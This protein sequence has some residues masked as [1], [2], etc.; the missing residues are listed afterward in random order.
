M[1]LLSAKKYDSEST[2]LTYTS[3]RA[4]MPVKVTVPPAVAYE[5]YD[6]DTRA[7]SAAGHLTVEG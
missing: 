1:S 2:W 4:T 6:P 3:L 5:Y 7:R